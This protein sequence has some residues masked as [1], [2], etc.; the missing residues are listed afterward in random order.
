MRLRHSNNLLGMVYKQFGFQVSRN[1]P[2]M[3]NLRVAIHLDR[4]SL[5]HKERISLR[6]T[7]YKYRSNMGKGGIL[8]HCMKTHMGIASNMLSLL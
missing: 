5:L 7:L 1:Q 3:H 2:G 8:G 4:I 6:W